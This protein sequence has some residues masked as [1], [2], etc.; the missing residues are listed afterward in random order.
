MLRLWTS[1]SIPIALDRTD[2]K[3]K[4]VSQWAR[5]RISGLSSRDD[6]ELEYE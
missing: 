4:S 1:F 3:K 5:P 6:A 2:A